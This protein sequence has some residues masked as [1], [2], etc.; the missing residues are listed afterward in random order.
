MDQL[1]AELAGD[2]ER[3]VALGHVVVAE[4]AAAAFALDE[5]LAVGAEAAVEDLVGGFVEL[6]AADH[7][8]L[9][10]EDLLE[11]ARSLRRRVRHA[12]S[13]SLAT[14]NSLAPSLGS[15]ATSVTLVSDLDA[16]LDRLRELHDRLDQ[17]DEQRKAL[18]RERDQA[19][20]TAKDAGATYAVIT[21]VTGLHNLA[22]S[23]ALK[24]ARLGEQ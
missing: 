12:L 18:M 16:A 14:S 13:V 4:H 19:L 17:H 1:E 2:V 10:V 22:I 23:D 15:L 3:V 8:V 24:R 21:A 20:R 5:D 9:Q 11:Q 6:A 7:E